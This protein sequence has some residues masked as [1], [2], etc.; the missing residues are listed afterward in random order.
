MRTA[1]RSPDDAGGAG[2]HADALRRAAHRARHL[3]RSHRWLRKP[4]GW[5]SRQVGL[6][7]V[8]STLHRLLG[9][10]RGYIRG[11]MGPAEVVRVL[12]AFQEAGLR[13]WVTGGWGVEAL[14]RAQTRTHDDLDLVLAEYERSEPAARKVLGSLGYVHL[15]ST[16]DDSC[17]MPRCSSFEDAVGHR[18]ELVSLAWEW[19]AAELGIVVKAGGPV[20][21]HL[22]QAVSAV[23]MVGDRQVPCLSA[24]AQVFLHSNYRLRLVQRHDLA[25]LARSFPESKV[26]LSG[27]AR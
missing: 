17:Q 12:D 20:P 9:P 11:E 3:V 23:G 27:R 25:T 2:H 1:E 19:L 5:A 10:I 13:F 6:A 24:D 22:V 7:P 18:V 4:L 21:D 15:F 26:V 16:R 14:V 8:G